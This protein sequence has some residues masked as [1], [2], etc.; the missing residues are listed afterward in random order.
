MA[1]IPRAVL[2]EHFQDR[3]AG[4]RLVAAVF[5]TFRFDPGFFEQEILPVFLDVTVSHATPIKLVQLED[6]LRSVPGN[7]AVYYDQNGLVAGAAGARLDVKRIPVRHRTG[8]FHPKNV[9]ALVEDAEPDEAGRR[10][11]ALL[12]S[13]LS[14]NLTQAG[15]W[16]NVEVCHTE[17]IHEG[18]PTRLR[19]DAVGFLERLERRVGDKAAQGHGALRTIRDFLRGAIQ[20]THRTTDGTLHTHF[21]DGGSPFPEFLKQLTGSA[22]DG[23]NLEILSPYFDAGP[24]SIPLRAL[25][26]TFRPREV[27]VFLP[28]KDSGE[29]LCTDGLYDW[30]RSQRNTSWANLPKD[31]LRGGKGDDVRQRTVHAKVYRF[32]S[33]QP[34]REILFVGSVNLTSPAH[35]NG[36]NLETGFLVEV[37]TPRRPDWW[38]ESHDKKPRAFEPSAEDEGTATSGGT[39]LSLRY[40]WN[41]GEADALWDDSTA[42]PRLIVQR[43]G[44][45]LFEVDALPP[46][47]WTPLPQRACEAMEGVLRSTSL[48][49]VLAPGKEPALLLV[50]E[51][52]MSHRPSLLFDLSPAEILRYWSLLTADQ[53]AAFLDARA[54]ELALRGEGAALVARYAPLAEIDTLF[55]RF[56][57]IFHAFG[58]LERSV[59]EALHE[60]KEREATYRLFGRKYDSLGSLLARVA[61]DDAEGKGELIEH[62]VIALCAR[63]IVQEIR[64]EH[65]DFFVE[66]AA[67]TRELQAQLDLVEPLR[68][69][70]AARNPERMGPFL[71]WFERWFLR[72]AAPVEQEESS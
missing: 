17:E 26:E 47:G 10:G 15:W 16:E 6:A 67:E 31:L 54:P 55:D 50:Q 22:L 7:I 40:F 3:L 29:A 37:P 46:G 24:E 43:Q 36:G 19:D 72:R 52:G 60:G 11:R 5:L 71:E 58:C 18:E 45:T 49:T 57:G 53:R 30:V 8:I 12:F 33:A 39:R 34:K 21:F 35:Q 20:R 14:A 61:K 56:A 59:R 68:A 70:L 62:Y 9:F 64:Q 32:F 48:L 66:H 41:T 27:R 13:S 42:S 25:Q 63:Q 51:E 44:V 1:E 38:L 4:R 2:S 23:M 28:R 69:R 65:R